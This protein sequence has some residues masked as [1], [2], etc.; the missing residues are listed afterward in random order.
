M[1]KSQK[2]VIYTLTYTAVYAIIIVSEGR[3]KKAPDRK[4]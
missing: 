3:Y 4:R 1:Q 2:N